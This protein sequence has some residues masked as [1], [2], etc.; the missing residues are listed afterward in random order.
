[1]KPE[2]RFLNQPKY[3]SPKCPLPRNKQKGGKKAPAYFTGIVNMLVEASIQGLPCDY[4]PRRL[5]TVT[6]SG[7]PY[8]WWECG[9]SYLCRIIDMLH[10]GYVESFIWL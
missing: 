9:R 5:T 10:M 4:N 6:R 8:T 2:R 7:V 1:M 3:F